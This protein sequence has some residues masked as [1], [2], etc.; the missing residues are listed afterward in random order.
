MG[1]EKALER[2]KKDEIFTGALIITTDLK[3]KEEIEL[4]LEKLD[5]IK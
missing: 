4:E 2:K 1:K 3:L 5:E